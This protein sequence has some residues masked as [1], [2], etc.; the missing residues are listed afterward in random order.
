MSDEWRDEQNIRVAMELMDLAQRQE[1]KGNLDEALR[2]A[3][4]SMET[5]R[6]I[7]YPRGQAT[8][9]RVIE[10]IKSLIVAKAIRTEP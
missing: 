4:K 1:S 5:I 2:L 8:G 3:E 7:D 9:S 10:H 6:D